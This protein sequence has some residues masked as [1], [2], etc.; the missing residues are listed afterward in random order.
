MIPQYFTYKELYLQFM[1]GKRVHSCLTHRFSNDSMFIGHNER[2]KSL[3]SEM[4]KLWVLI[5]SINEL[6]ND[7]P[8]WRCDT[9]INN[10]TYV[11]SVIDTELEVKY[12]GYF[13]KL[14]TCLKTTID[15]IDSKCKVNLEFLSEECERSYSIGVNP[16]PEDLCLVGDYNIDYNEDYF[17]EICNQETRST[18]PLITCDK[19]YRVISVDKVTGELLIYDNVS[20]L[21]IGDSIELGK[22]GK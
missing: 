17:V 8:L 1:L 18:L 13:N 21:K 15:R 20:G 4:G 12:I 10:V 11:P 19:T 2:M 7:N 14:F 22:K 6:F 16:N 5:E 3:Y 9:L